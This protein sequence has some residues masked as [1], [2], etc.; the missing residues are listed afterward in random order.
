MFQDTALSRSRLTLTGW[1]LLEGRLQFRIRT[2]QQL[3]AMSRETGVIGQ[4][5]VGRG[6]E[7]EQLATWEVVQGDKVLPVLGVRPGD[8]V[9][10]LD[11]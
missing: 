6:A 4:P 10:E 8:L 2:F 3:Q 11:S 1:V 7:A 9:M 5:V